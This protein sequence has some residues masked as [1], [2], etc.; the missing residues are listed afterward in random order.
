MTYKNAVKKCPKG[1]RIPTLKELREE[2]ENEDSFIHSYEKGKDIFFWALKE[3]NY[4][5]GLFRLSDG[6]W[7]GNVWSGGLAKSNS[8][9]RVVYVRKKK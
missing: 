4:L 1:Y 3:D 8:G 6:D 5:R 9:G 2:A 7:C